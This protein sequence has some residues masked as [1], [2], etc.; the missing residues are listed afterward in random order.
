MK[1]KADGLFFLYIIIIM[2][3]MIMIVCVYAR[4]EIKR[5]EG[6]ICGPTF[7]F[8]FSHLENRRGRK[9]VL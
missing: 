4:T 9:S 3:M 7:F 1:S 2:M 6:D 5:Q 8:S